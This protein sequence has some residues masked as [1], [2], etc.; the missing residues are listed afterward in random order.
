MFAREWGSER[1]EKKPP[2]RHPQELPER[3]QQKMESP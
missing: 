3:H 1:H 2:E